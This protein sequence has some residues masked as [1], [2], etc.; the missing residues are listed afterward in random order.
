MAECASS[1]RNQPAV[2]ELPTKY[3]VSE[4]IGVLKAWRLFVGSCE[5]QVGKRL[6]NARVHAIME[7]HFISQ[8]FLTSVAG[9]L[10]RKRNFSGLL[11]DRTVGN[12]RKRDLDFSIANVH[13]DTILYVDAFMKLLA[14][15]PLEY[16]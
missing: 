5:E 9:D 6:S 15:R 1:N 13:H 12:L 4:R 7:D 3:R 2:I 11:C 10:P 16:F 14:A 8:E